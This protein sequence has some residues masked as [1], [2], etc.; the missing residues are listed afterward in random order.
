MRVFISR[1]LAGPIAVAVA[2]LV[3][4]GLGAEAIAVVNAVADLIVAAV[5]LS[6]Y[7]IT[8]RLIDRQVNPSDVAVK[9]AGV[10]PPR[11]L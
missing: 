11:K 9:E 7:G 5:G 3:S 2:W 1:L 10:A 4:Q 8:H 6:A